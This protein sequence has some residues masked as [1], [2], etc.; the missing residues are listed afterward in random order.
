MTHF[1]ALAAIIGSLPVTLTNGTVADATQVMSDFNFIVA[2]VN[3]NAA[4][5]ANTPQLA[6]ANTFTAVQSGPAATAQANY[7]TAGQ[8]Q[9]ASLTTLTSTI[10]TNT[11]TANTTQIP[12]PAYS[13]GQIFTFIPSQ[14]NTGAATL[15]INGL[16]AK[17][18]FSLGSATSGGELVP[19]IPSM[20]EYDGTNFNILSNIRPRPFTGPPVGTV[21]TAS[22]TSNVALANTGTYFD[23][24]SLTLPPGTWSFQ[25][26]VTVDDTAGAPANFNAKLWDGTNVIASTRN[27]MAIAGGNSLSIALSGALAPVGPVRISV[28]D[29]TSTSG[30][31]QFNI[32]GNSKDSTL[33]ATKIA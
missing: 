26:T 19:L 32:S 2:Q 17:S 15:N 20:V 31:I 7:P 6:S 25:G 27:L 5:L 33:T 21:F 3:A 9:N 24:P 1:I 23:G 14:Q 29:V 28:Q 8:V 11:I 12:L 18:I 13:T 4:T 30:A 10:G 16:G 22:L